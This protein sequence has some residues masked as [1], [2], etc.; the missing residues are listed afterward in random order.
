LTAADLPRPSLTLTG[1]FDKDHERRYSHVPFEVPAGLRQIHIRYSYSDQIDSD[2]L[3][4]GGN[5]LDIG[6]F[7][8][9][10]IAEGSPGFRGWS[11]SNKME[12]TVDEGWATPP[13]RKGRIG[14]GTWHVLLGPYKVGPRGCDWKVE[15]WFDPGLR[16]PWKSASFGGRR[17]DPDPL[18]EARP[19]WLRGDLHCH[20]LYSDGDSWPP[21]MLNAA[22]EAGLDFLGVTDHNNV[23]HQLAYG[24]G[25][26]GLPIVL[27]G[28]EVT[29]YGGHW[30]AWGTDRWWEFREPESTAVE[31]TMRAAAESGAVVSV[32]HPKPVGPPWE[33]AMDGGFHA[34]EVWNGPWPQ[35][36]TAALAYWEQLLQRGTRCAAVG[37]SDT[38]YLK[39]GNAP[40]RHQDTLGTPTTWVHVDGRPTVSAILDA[41]REGRSF[42]S[43]SPRGPQLYLEQDRGRA[44]RVSVEVRDG[45]GATLMVL[46]DSGPL[47]A[48]P[49]NDAAWDRAFDVPAG[50]TYV[51]AQLVDANG[52]MR[53]VTN[54]IW[55]DRL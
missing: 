30:N 45:A 7:D 55:A 37:G 43:Q 20:T 44:G 51:R 15:I 41:L 14:A 22:A 6:L 40:L 2:P 34:V 46:S 49:V 48:A 53:A 16:S 24:P 1:R 42:V 12:L 23:G 18:P 21:E 13:Y 9:R 10:G 36:N 52:D 38:H 35:L 5:T 11:G 47:D 19:G 54:P 39:R 3:V 4:G 50:L 31:R 29:T 17:L 33:Y 8:E 32:C 27:P 28:V 25:G 26:N